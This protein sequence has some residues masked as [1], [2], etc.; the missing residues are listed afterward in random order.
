MIKIVKKLWWLI[1]GGVGIGIYFILK[2]MGLKQKVDVISYRAK[3]DKK[4]LDIDLDKDYKMK[5]IE[6]TVKKKKKLMREAMKIPD[7]R[8]RLQKLAD[9]LNNT[10]S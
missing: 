10:K 1:I 6:S 9:I 8:K 7:K 2:K 3:L 4:L 5:E